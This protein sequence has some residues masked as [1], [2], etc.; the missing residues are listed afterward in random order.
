[1]SNEIILEISNI[2]KKKSI[3]LI[4]KVYNLQLKNKKKYTAFTKTKSEVKGGGRKPWKQKGTGNARSGSIRSSIWVGGGI[5]FGPKPR[6]VEKKINKKEKLK[7]NLACLFLKSK[8]IKLLSDNETEILLNIKKTVDLKKKLSEFKF[9]STD[10]ILLILSEFSK[11]LF[12]SVRNIKQIK[13]L[14]YP[15]LNLK[16]ILICDYIL[17]S[18]KNLLALKTL[19]DKYS[20]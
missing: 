13:L 1:M 15:I 14:V 10:K 7:A 20:N 3:G 16:Q 17:I 4:H 8:K 18:K 5:S 2:K 9:K 11:N 19:Y 12:L 6:T